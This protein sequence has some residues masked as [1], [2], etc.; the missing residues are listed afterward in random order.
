LTSTG[1]WS[2]L[3]FLPVWWCHLPVSATAKSDRTSGGAKCS[4]ETIRG[5]GNGCRMSLR[6]AVTGPWSIRFFFSVWVVSPPGF[7]GGQIWP[8]PLG[9]AKAPP[10]RFEGRET[11]SGG[12]GDGKCSSEGIRGSENGFRR[13]CVLPPPVH[14]RY[15]FFF[16]V[17]VVSPSG[18]GDGQICLTIIST[19]TTQCM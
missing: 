3:L 13:R 1:S 8:P 12:S 15:R 10:R 17:L 14:G 4:P 9:T 5:S 6:F 18:F 7:G 2:I 16:S 11:G 19:L